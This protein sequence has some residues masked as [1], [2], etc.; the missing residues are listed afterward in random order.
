MP[1]ESRIRYG[2]VTDPS[3]AGEPL[4]PRGDPLPRRGEAPPPPPRR[5]APSQPFGDL[6]SQ[7]T[8]PPP[9]ADPLSEGDVPPPQAA[10]QPPE[11]GEPLPQ[12][13]EPLP[14]RGEPL[15]KR[16]ESRPQG[17]S[18]HSSWFGEPQPPADPGPQRGE[19]RP[20]AADPLPQRGEPLPQRGVPQPQAPGPLPGRGEP[21]PQ[22]GVPQ[23]QAPDP[24]PRR[25][26][27]LPQRGEPLP[28]RGEPLPQ[29]GDPS[30]DPSALPRRVN[31]TRRSGRHRSAHRLS[32]PSDA[33][34]LLIAVPG[35]ASL[36]SD[37]VSGEI[38]D[39]TAESCQGA[40]I[41]VAYLEGSEHRLDEA[42]AA[43]AQGPYPAL[44]V[45]VPLLAGPNPKADAA[46]QRAVAG[47][48]G[49]VVLAEH[50]GP[51]PLLA[52][53]L[54]ARLAQVGLARESRVR[55]LSISNAANGVL[56]LADRGDDAVRAAGVA[57]VLLAGRLAAPVV[58]A[59]IDD[60]PAVASAVTRLREMGASRVAI[61]PCVIGPE[62]DPRELDAVSAAT[63]ALCAPPLGAHPAIGQLVAM[64]YGNA[65][66]GLRPADSSL[67]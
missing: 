56:V 55:G 52:E 36:E 13:S 34:T 40:H 33:P 30:A 46:L 42:V 49:E 20:Q 24:L 5:G 6:L 11:R 62:T 1:N 12:R 44:A 17:S 21:L 57:A 47:A 19:P 22:R 32:L 18:E 50:L 4:P 63:G 2:S 60:P 28:Q 23:P 7:F 37:R 10:T 29:R 27:P 16:G 61:A 39:A 25:G 48:A 31:R 45:I 14:K 58:H 3:Q 38:A 43:P 15:P 64:R 53:A 66:V 26:E 59:S 51:H 67:G 9:A 35:S 41:Q 65:L 54:H 8:G